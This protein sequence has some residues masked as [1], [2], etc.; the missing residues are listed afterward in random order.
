MPHTQQTAINNPVNLDT[1]IKRLIVAD[2]SLSGFSGHYYEYARAIGNAAAKAGIK[3]ILVGNQSFTGTS[4]TEIL[5]Y[6]RLQTYDMT[7]S[8]LPTP[9]RMMKTALVHAGDLK[10][11]SRQQT[12]GNTD[13]V[14][15]PTVSL[16]VLFGLL[17]AFGFRWRRKN[18]PI[19]SLVLRDTMKIHRPAV[20]T[21]TSLFFNLAKIFRATRWL[22]ICV[23]TNELKDEYSTIT[24]YPITVLPI[25][26]ERDTIT[27][28][29]DVASNEQLTISMLGDARLGKGIDM[30]PDL[31]EDLLLDYPDQLQFIIQTSRPVIGADSEV[32]DSTL[33]RL[34]QIELESEH[35]KLLPIPLTTEEYFLTIA[36]SDIMLHPYRAESYRY[37]SSGMFAEALALGKV[38]VVPNKTWMSSELAKIGGGGISFNVGN[39]SSLSESVREIIN[40]MDQYERE[41]LNVK[42]IWLSIHNSDQALSKI[43]RTLPNRI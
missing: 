22:Q 29:I 9:L 15:M 26:I 1:T 42:T 18:M 41:A 6:F 20:R 36:R 8:N 11:L 31:I 21:L 14:L 40:N 19:V 38:V 2:P 12:L 30:I 10:R 24:S 32:L 33:K 37:Q 3:P 7:D 4:S 13:L 17:F 25:P 27:G 35:L 39:S 34:N 5:P 16:P 23:D 28:I 43:I